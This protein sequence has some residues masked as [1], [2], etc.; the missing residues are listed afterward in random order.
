MAAA[1][2]PKLTNV[3][4]KRESETHQ[5]LGAAI[6]M[7]QH[8]KIQSFLFDLAKEMIRK[9]R[10]HQECIEISFMDKLQDHYKYMRL[11]LGFAVN[12]ESAN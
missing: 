9:M 8:L 3:S 4:A 11:L 7:Q 2:D 10:D 5:W 6:T 12:S 1:V